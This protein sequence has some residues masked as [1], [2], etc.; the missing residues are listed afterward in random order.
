MRSLFMKIQQALT[1]IE[2]E[3]GAFEIKCLVASDP[4]EPLWDLILSAA[5]FEPNRKKNLD[6]LTHRILDD[7]DYDELSHFSAIILYLPNRQ[8]PLAEALKLIQSNHRAGQYEPLRADG[9][10]LIRTP[11][12]QARLVMPIDDGSADTDAP[13]NPER[14]R[15]ESP[16]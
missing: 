14:L 7:L 3:K 4:L 10:V 13:H 1:V 11:M 16:C 9:M 8:H 15:I 6:Y 5:W 2:Q 12:E